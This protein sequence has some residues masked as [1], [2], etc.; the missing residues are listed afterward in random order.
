VTLLAGVARAADMSKCGS[1]RWSL[2][3]SWD[4]RPA[5]LVV[6]FNP[7]TADGFEDDPTISLL[8][9]IAAHNGYGSIIVVNGIPLRSPTPAQ[10]IEMTRWAQRGEWSDRDRMQDNVAAIV[11]ECERAG[12]VLIAW[13]ALADRCALWFEHVLEEIEC[14]VRE[15]TP[16][17]CLGKTAA[18]YPKHPLARGKHKVPKNAALV[19]WKG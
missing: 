8:C 3:R 10:A 1:F 17:Y 7:S 4:T 13:G 18:G 11:R 6:M 19:P 15:G 12:A 9:H 5:L 2:M 14:A 16:I